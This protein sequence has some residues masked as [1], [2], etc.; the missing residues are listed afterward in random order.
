MDPTAARPSA[1]PGRP[2]VRLSEP[3]EIAAALPH[4]LGFHPRESV[5][6]IALGG[7]GGRL[8]QVTA[9]AD[10]P[11]RWDA[12]EL[13]RSMAD[14]I[15]REQVVAAIVA[16]VSEAEDVDGVAG[17]ADLPHRAL[18]HQLVL[19]LAAHDVPVR[20]ALL[21]RGGRW[22]SFDCPHACCAAGAGTPLPEGTSELAAESVANG[23]VV[24]A[25][26]AELAGR[27]APVGDLGA[28][29]AAAVLRVGQA[30]AGR[31]LAEGGDVVAAASWS[32]VTDAVARLGPGQVARL[33]DED[34]ARVAWGLRDPAVR[35]R[36][37]ALCLGDD[38]AAAEQLWI[39]CVRRVPAPLDAAPATLL[40]VIAWLRGD[41]ASAGLALERARASDPG[42]SLAALLEEALD[43]CVPPAE[44]RAL[45]VA[46]LGR[47]GPGAATRRRPG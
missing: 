7:S 46:G 9:R 2:E 10:L 14:R 25:D 12:A 6:L 41:G 44:L 37:I 4:L 31:K 45:V 11:R 27:I 29:M 28:A 35:D 24:A 40:A 30:L 47:C 23:R 18:V 15:S 43:A 26:R 33:P 1:P 8:V 32:A 20:E 5:V 16:V 19:A 34:V 22:W 39:E 13:A 36:A 42:Y 3:G 21:V 38:A 17:G